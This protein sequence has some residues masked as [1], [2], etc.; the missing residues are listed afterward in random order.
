MEVVRIYSIFSHISRAACYHLPLK[1]EE[2]TGTPG[3]RRRL[4]FQCALLP[5]V[6]LGAVGERIYS[7]FEILLVFVSS[8]EVVVNS[9]FP[10]GFRYYIREN[11]SRRNRLL[12][13][14]LSLEL[15]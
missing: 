9:H 14:P 12:S 15:S 2:H 3:N 11:A 10:S 5:L 7:T 6:G 8:S 1:T 4:A 13:E